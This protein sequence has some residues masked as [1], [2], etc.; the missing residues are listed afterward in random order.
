M[1]DGLWFTVDGQKHT[2]F[3]EFRFANLKIQK[4][5]LRLEEVEAALAMLFP[6]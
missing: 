6:K 1:V 4:Y 2:H 5:V 3:S